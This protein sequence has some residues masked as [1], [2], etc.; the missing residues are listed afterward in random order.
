[1][2][3]SISD[4]DA[5]WIFDPLLLTGIVTPMEAFLIKCLYNR[6]LSAGAWVRDTV[7]TR[8]SIVDGSRSVMKLDRLVKS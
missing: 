1:M 7:V 4:D 3:I 6:S 5:L 2:I 8:T